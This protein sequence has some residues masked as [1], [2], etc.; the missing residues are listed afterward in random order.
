M[1]R[2]YRRVVVFRCLNRLDKTLR[3]RLAVCMQLPD[4]ATYM[5]EY[6]TAK[7]M[8]HEEERPLS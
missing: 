3:N 5:S 6:D 7:A 2:C 1:E 8:R 4:P